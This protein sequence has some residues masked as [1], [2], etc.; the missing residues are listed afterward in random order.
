MANTLD[1]LASALAVQPL[2]AEEQRLLLDAARD[3]AHGSERRYAPLSAFLLGL[4]VAGADDRGAAL[5]DALT[6]VRGVLSAGG[7]QP[8]S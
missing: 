6:R 4:A 2:D 8:A 3:V 1:D 5:T 7:D